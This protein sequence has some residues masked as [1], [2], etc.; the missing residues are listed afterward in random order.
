MKTDFSSQPSAVSRQSEKPAAGWSEK[1]KGKGQKA[2]GKNE[3]KKLWR[4]NSLFPADGWLRMADRFSPTIVNCQLPARSQFSILNSQLSIDRLLLPVFFFLLCAQTGCAQRQPVTMAA[5]ENAL[6]VAEKTAPQQTS[7]N[8]EPAKLI[9]GSPCLFR[10]TAGKSVRSIS[11]TW[12]GKQVFFSFDQT[13]GQW[14]GFAGVD[15]DTKAGG[16]QLALEMTDASGQGTNFHQVVTIEK[17]FYR[18]TGI[19]VPKKYVEPDPADLAR[20]Q[21]ERELKNELFSRLEPQKFWSGSFAAPTMSSLTA[22]FGSQRTY[23]GKRQSI[24]QGQDFRAA[25]GTPVKA[26]NEAKVMLARNLY[27]EGG[28][29]VLDHGQGLLSIY[30]HLSAFNVKEG[31]MVKKGQVIALSG[32]S[33]R[34]TGPH[35]H[36]GVRWQGIYVDPATLLKMKLP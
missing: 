29:V 36:M 25:V 5:T 19:T 34:V 9:N 24:H 1:S 7:V 16:H 35:L 12:L 20:I 21:S 15:I 33:G 28:C 18:V 8:W 31:E 23:N 10:V 13:S 27:Y 6:T 14:F 11:G 26:V 22:E 17:G 2:K 32:V 3:N 30:M 4:D